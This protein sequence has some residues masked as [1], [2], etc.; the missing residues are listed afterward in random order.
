MSIVCAL[1]IVPSFCSRVVSLV[2][3]IEAVELEC[4]V[5]IVFTSSFSV[6]SAVSEIVAGLASETGLYLINSH[7]I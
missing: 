2:E 3:T 4:D 5:S 1:K 6:D 7:S